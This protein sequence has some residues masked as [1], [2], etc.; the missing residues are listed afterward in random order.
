MSKLS[1]YLSINDLPTSCYVPLSF[2]VQSLSCVWLFATPCTAACQASLSFTISENLHKLKSIE[3]M[4][5]YSHLILCCPLLLL[6]SIFS[7]IRV[8]SK[9]LALRIRKPKHWSFFYNPVNVDN[10]FSNS[11]AFS[12]SSLYIWNCSVHLLLKPSLKDFEDYL[13]SMWDECSCMV[14]WTLFGITLL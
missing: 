1:K 8:F 6:L 3:S 7:S 12:R 11:S 13:A 10:L 2:V 5:P 4:M 14:V 9:E